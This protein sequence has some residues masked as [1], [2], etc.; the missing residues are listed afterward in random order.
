[1]MD[2]FKYGGVDFTE[3]E[4]LEAEKNSPEKYDEMRAKIAAWE[5]KY[6]KHTRGITRK[7][8]ESPS[9]ENINDNLASALEQTVETE[10]F[11]EDN[12]NGFWE[13]VK[14]EFE[15]LKTNIAMDYNKANQ[16][17]KE[18]NSLLQKHF[19]E[20]TNLLISHTKEKLNALTNGDF[21]EFGNASIRHFKEHLETAKRQSGEIKDFMGLNSIPIINRVDGSRPGENDGPIKSYKPSKYS[22]ETIKK[23]PEQQSVGL[24]LQ[25]GEDIGQHFSDTKA[26]KESLDSIKN[27]NNISD[28][29]KS[30]VIYAALDSHPKEA[31]DF[32]KEDENISNDLKIEVAKNAIE[33]CT[34]DATTYV[35]ATNLIK[36]ANKDDPFEALR[37]LDKPDSDKDLINKKYE[38]DHKQLWEVVGNKMKNAKD[39]DK[40]SPEKLGQTLAEEFY[41]SDRNVSSELMKEISIFTQANNNNKDFVKAFNKEANK[42]KSVKDRVLHGKAVKSQ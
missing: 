16:Q 36:E 2:V 9:D 21:K 17:H 20:N 19:K 22:V 39:G 31:L 32:A 18:Q 42:H 30:E 35:L 25:T 5:A 4:F 8:E 40:Y 29:L 10:F 15:K 27:N 23:E 12:Q 1:M 7:R 24:K 14:N 26:V 33:K 37:T 34:H 38:Y 6:P 11:G 41:R 28:E 13:S 3:E